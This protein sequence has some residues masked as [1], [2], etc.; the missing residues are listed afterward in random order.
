[1]VGAEGKITISPCVFLPEI[2]PILQKN[3][4]EFQRGLTAWYNLLK[5]MWQRG[6][7]PQIF[8]T[9]ATSFYRG[10]FRC[11]FRF[12]HL[13]QPIRD[14]AE[15]WNVDVASEPEDY[16][17]EVLILHKD[18]LLRLNEQRFMFCVT[19]KKLDRE[20]KLYF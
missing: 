2:R 11:L 3:F 18:L 13:L 6:A 14:L 4:P 1:M 17:D 7:H 10:I 19:K 5:T 9:C 15:N 20:A 16:L 12:V 8:G